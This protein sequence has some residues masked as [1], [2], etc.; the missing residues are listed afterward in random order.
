MF[1]PC[2]V[3]CVKGIFEILAMGVAEITVCILYSPGLWHPTETNSVT[4]NIENQR[5]LKLGTNPLH[6]TM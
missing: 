5:P 2:I 6:R 1:S 4:L 3:G